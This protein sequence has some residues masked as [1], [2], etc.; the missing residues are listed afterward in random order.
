MRATQ[1]SPAPTDT[2]VSFTTHGMGEAFAGWMR[3]LR[4]PAVAQL[5]VINLL[6]TVAFT[7]MEAVFPLFTQHSFGWKAI[8]NG[9]VFTYAGVVIVLMQGSLVGQLVKRWGERSL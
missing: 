4:N 2:S 1:A 7:A 8:Q 6:F 3:V 9:Y 5:V